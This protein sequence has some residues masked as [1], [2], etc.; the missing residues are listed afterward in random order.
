MLYFV[1]YVIIGL[2]R[3]VAYFMT[4]YLVMLAEFFHGIADF[5]ILLVLRQS[6]K[7][8][9][10]PADE[11]HP[12][13]H[14]LASNLGALTA[15]IAFITLV[16]F[17]LIREGFD[18][19]LNPV[20]ATTPEI[21]VLALIVSFFILLLCLFL[22]RKK[23]GVS[24]KA[25][26]TELLNDIISTTAAIAGILLS[27][28]Y[29]YAD[30]AFAIFIALIIAINAFRLYRENASILLG[31]SPDAGFYEKLREIVSSFREIR[32]VHDVLAIF[33]GEGK[34]HLDMHLHV[35]GNM[36][37]RDADEL[38]VRVASRVRKEM[39][40]IAYVSIHVCPESSDRLKTTYDQFQID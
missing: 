36:S 11:E 5:V 16:S 35:D 14:G 30:G 40:E 23:E 33:I 32:D 15:A 20:E 19:I 18:K 37:V 38:T 13:G 10:R 31:K 6:R 2:I 4:G 1:V 29:H 28:F 7:I 39:P 26:K 12:F 25:I 22:A 17:E 9:L 21:A 8:S 3:I 24:E 34:V 27:G